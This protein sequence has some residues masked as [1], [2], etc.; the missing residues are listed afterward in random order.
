MI[1]KGTKVII[2]NPV[3]VIDKKYMLMVGHVLN[4]VA[5]NLYMI[6]FAE[7]LNDLFYEDEFTVLNEQADQ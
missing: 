6:Q 3:A 4:I 2:T 7:D 5:K 1:P